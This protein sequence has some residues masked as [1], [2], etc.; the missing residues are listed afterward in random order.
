[1]AELDSDTVIRESAYVVKGTYL[2][3]NNTGSY[4]EKLQTPGQKVGRWVRG[5]F[6]KRS[7][8]ELF[9]IMKGLYYEF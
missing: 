5:K 1:M 2:L 6:S 9:N 4:I 7:L 3:Q 8:V